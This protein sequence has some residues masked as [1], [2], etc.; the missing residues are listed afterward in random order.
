MDRAI[1]D[2]Y[3]ALA[4]R[5]DEDRF[6]NSYGG[7]L[8]AQER[9]LLARWL[10]VGAARVLDLG[11]GTGRL[12]DRA[13]HACDASIESLRAAT[14]RGAARFL[15]ADIAALPFATE[16]FD[17]AYCLHVFMHL[18]RAAIAEAFG[19]VARI[20]RPGGI[21]VAD[22]AS[23]LRRRLLRRAPSGWHGATSLTRAE[24]AA[25]AAE[26][27]LRM[28]DGA[29]IMLA[30]VH[31]LPPALRAPIAAADRRLAALAPDLASY[32]VGR[33]VRDRRR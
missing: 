30:P 18:N 8:D 7:F 20:L 10:P 28:I 14:G 1:I 19:E 23:S 25:L 12:S 24:F 6:G 3:D 31:R 22:I 33:F 2:Y 32:I 5:Y 4:P 13:S 29:G 15:A 27:G 16:S 17:A 26:A 9:A 21:F 11:C